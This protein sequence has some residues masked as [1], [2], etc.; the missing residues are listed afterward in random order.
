MVVSNPTFVSY[1]YADMEIGYFHHSRKIWIS[2]RLDVV[3]MWSLISSGERVT[4]WCVGKE[5]PVQASKKRPPNH[6]KENEPPKKASKVSQVEILRE[7]VKDYET[8][9][10]YKLWAEML[11][12]GSHGSLDNPPQVAMFGREKT[13]KAIHGSDLMHVVSVFDIM[14]C[15]DP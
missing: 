15:F 3:D 13:Q 1:I 6:K 2:S 8:K 9:F 10:Q 12:R 11:A 4:F 7:Q 5:S 14:F